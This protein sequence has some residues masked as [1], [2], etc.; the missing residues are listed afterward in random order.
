MW[1]MIVPCI[2]TYLVGK[3][4]PI[5]L[6]WTTL[7]LILATAHQFHRYYLLCAR[8]GKLTSLARCTK[9]RLSEFCKHSSVYSATLFTN[10]S[11]SANLLN[12]LFLPLAKQLGPI[13]LFSQKGNGSLT[14][15]IHSD[16]AVLFAKVSRYFDYLDMLCF[17]SPPLSGYGVLFN[18]TAQNQY[19]E[20]HVDGFPEWHFSSVKSAQRAQISPIK[21]E[22]RPRKAHTNSQP[23]QRDIQEVSLYY[24]SVFYIQAWF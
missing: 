5:C 16:F 20:R 13:S 21:R 3:K 23:R 7:S 19:Y 24:L 9:M 11:C 10:A 6:L 18:L 4:Y 22:E 12:Q 14:S 1:R 8:A 2:R 15:F 17:A